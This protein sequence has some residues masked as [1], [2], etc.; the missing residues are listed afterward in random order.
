MTREQRKKK[1]QLDLAEKYNGLVDLVEA[2]TLKVEKG[3]YNA[4]D[5]AY[6]RDLKRRKQIVA[7]RIKAFSV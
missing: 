5:W 6:L 7:T 4:E 1:H 2:W 3:P